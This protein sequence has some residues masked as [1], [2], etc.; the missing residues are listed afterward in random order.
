[1]P[2]GNDMAL[3]E[4]AD[5]GTRHS[6]R[7]SGAYVFDRVLSGADALAVVGGTGLGLSIC[8][9]IVEAHGGSIRAAKPA[10]RGN[11]H[12]SSSPL[13][14]RSVGDLAPMNPSPNEPAL[15]V[16]VV[17]DEPANPAVSVHVPSSA[18]GYEVFEAT[19]GPERAGGRDRPPAR[20]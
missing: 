1:V 18:H 19:D 2:A 17:D 8:H 16:L 15:R 9:G 4:V 3:I 11:A 20:P 7:G 14:L 10:R 5:R 12:A 13:P 6:S